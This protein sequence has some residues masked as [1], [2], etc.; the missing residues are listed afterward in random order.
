MRDRVRRAGVGRMTLAAAVGA[1]GVLALTGWAH[2]P[3]EASAQ[4]RL[5]PPTDGGIVNAT[6]QRKMMILELQ[7]LNARLARIEAKLDQPIAVR[8]A[9]GGEQR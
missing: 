9:S 2:R 1:F 6:D 5:T 7:A 4:P 8:S 3:V